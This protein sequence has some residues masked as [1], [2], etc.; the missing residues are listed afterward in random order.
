MEGRLDAVE[1]R[2]SRIEAIAERIDDRLARI[3][4]RESQLTGA[5]CVL[6]AVGTLVGAVATAIVGKLWK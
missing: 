5:W 2:L 6:A 4:A 1:D 3:E